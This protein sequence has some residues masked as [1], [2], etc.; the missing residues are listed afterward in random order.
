MSV[1]LGRPV[2]KYAWRCGREK[3]G[4]VDERFGALC[5]DLEVG[6]GEGRGQDVEWL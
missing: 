3:C 1:R 4:A 5:E 6:V 2:L